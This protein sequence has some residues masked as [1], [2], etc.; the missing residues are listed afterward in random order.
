M[1]SGLERAAYS[2]T[3]VLIEGARTDLTPNTLTSLGG[4]SAMDSSAG[5]RGFGYDP[6]TSNHTS[7]LLLT[8]NGTSAFA[9]TSGVSFLDSNSSTVTTAPGPSL[10]DYTIFTVAY[11]MNRYYLWV[12]FAFGFPGNIVS[13]ITVL[14]MKPFTSPTGYVAALAL[15][16][17]ACLVFKVGSN[18]TGET[19]VFSVNTI[20][21]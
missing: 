20:K 19:A 1:S 9:N 17:N 3:T 10:H 13:F 12:I 7:V 14:R 16:D 15:V 5:R 18:S 2:D 6:W 21:F 4:G 11:Y 8:D